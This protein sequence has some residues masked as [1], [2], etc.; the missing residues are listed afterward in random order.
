MG[1]AQV[2]VTLAE[3]PPVS[4]LRNQWWVSGLLT[5]AEDCER[6]G[7]IHMISAVLLKTLLCTNKSLRL[8]AWGQRG[9]GAHSGLI[10]TV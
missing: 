1:L 4:P 9:C 7:R 6:L 2:E 3:G 10:T 8:T 5:Q